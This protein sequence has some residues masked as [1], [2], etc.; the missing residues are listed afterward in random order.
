M[1]I[2]SADDGF[3]SIYE[4]DSRNNDDVVIEAKVDN[5]ENV[6]VKS[7]IQRVLPLF[8]YLVTDTGKIR[9]MVPKISRNVLASLRRCL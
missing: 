5:M 7:F 8:R 3:S 6:V 1:N 2:L 4:E 9:K